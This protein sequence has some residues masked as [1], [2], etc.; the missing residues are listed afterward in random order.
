MIIIPDVHGRQFWK[1]A[2]KKR[3]PE[4]HVVFLGDYLDPYGYEW[5]QGKNIDVWKEIWDN[6]NEIIEYKRKH[7]R[8]VTLLLGNHDCHYYFNGIGGGSRYDNFHA[9]VIRKKFQE[10]K[11]LFQLAYEKNIGGKRFIFS[12]AGIHKLWIEDWFGDS[13]TDKNVVRYLN[14]ALKTEDYSLIRALDQYSAYRG[15]IESYGSIIWADI[16]EWSKAEKSPFGDVQI[17]GHTQLN[18]EPINFGDVFY[19]LDVRRGFRIDENGNVCEMDGKIM[20]KSNK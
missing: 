20:P 3:K 18:G 4:E 12:H 14:D 17:F 5:P 2:V 10:N 11:H 15:G 6:F 13:V 16:R 1:D 19:D 9:S 8:T 7:P